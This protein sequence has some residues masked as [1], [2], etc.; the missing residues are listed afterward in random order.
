MSLTR[1]RDLLAAALLA[2]LPPALGLAQGVRIPLPPDADW[3]ARLEYDLPIGPDAHL[4]YQ[5]RDR[6]GRNEGH[7]PAGEHLVLLWTA[8]PD[9]M[10]TE[11]TRVAAAGRVLSSARDHATGIKRVIVQLPDGRVLAADHWLH[12]N[13]MVIA[14]AEATAADQPRAL[15]LLERVAQIRQRGGFGGTP[16]L[17]MP[18]PPPET[19]P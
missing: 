9:L 16:M 8:D 15:A 2:G 11:M 12:G 18:L 6:L 3:I 19:G 10:L 1:R 7:G 5:L 4:H 14:Q 13:G 17:M